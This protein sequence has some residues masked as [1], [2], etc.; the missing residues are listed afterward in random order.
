MPSL[1]FHGIFALPCMAGC[2][3][4]WLFGMALP[5]W[6]FCALPLVTSLAI[7]LSAA[8]CCFKRAALFATFAC[9]FF[10]F[11]STK[12]FA[13]F[14][15]FAF[16]LTTHVGAR[17]ASVAWRRALSFTPLFSYRPIFPLSA[18][19]ALADVCMPAGIAHAAWVAAARTH[20]HALR[21]FTRISS[22]T[23]FCCIAA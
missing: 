3:L 10:F 9:A 7:T 11:F 20:C 18:F 21:I 17:T 2:L 6:R 5:A 8:F 23:S 1:S 14:H 12:A 19:A 22:C 15:F 4:A 13:H 16:S